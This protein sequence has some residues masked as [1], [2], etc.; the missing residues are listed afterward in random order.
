MVAKVRADSGEEYDGY[1]FQG[2][3]DEGD[4]VNGVE[5]I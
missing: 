3:Q 2:T 1:V 4:V 5:Y